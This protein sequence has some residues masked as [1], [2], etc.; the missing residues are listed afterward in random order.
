MSLRRLVLLRRQRSSSFS[1]FSV[2]ASSGREEGAEKGRNITA[3]KTYSAA[4]TTGEEAGENA[5]ND[6]E[7]EDKAFAEREKKF[8][9]QRKLFRESLKMKNLERANGFTRKNLVLSASAL[10]MSPAV[11]DAIMS[12]GDEVPPELKLLEQCVEDMDEKLKRDLSRSSSGESDGFPET[13]EEKLQRV[14]FERVFMMEKYAEWWPEAVLKAVRKGGPGY[15]KRM[16]GRRMEIAES[17]AEFAFS[18]EYDDDDGDGDEN[19]NGDSFSS[20]SDSDSNNASSRISGNATKVLKRAD[21]AAIAG[22][23]SLGE[24]LVTVDFSRDRETTKK[25]L[26][27]SIKAFVDARRQAQT[28]KDY[29]EAW[30]VVDAIVTNG[31]NSLDRLVDV[32]SRNKK[33]DVFSFSKKKP[34]PRDALRVASKLLEKKQEFVSGL[35]KNKETKKEDENNNKNE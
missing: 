25:K 24:T 18:G 31:A 7:E 12:D 9:L 15:A 10:G 6:E 16:A 14:I 1:R 11:V 3:L 21:V 19:Y 20:S 28:V 32:A 34:S 22:L 4:T 26:R 13:A 33:D 29:A 35:F 8:M 2:V 23:L 30:T 17:I 27:L 5:K